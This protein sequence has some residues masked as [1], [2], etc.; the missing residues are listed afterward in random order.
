MSLDVSRWI[1]IYKAIYKKYKPCPWLF[2]C[3]SCC[4][5]PWCQLS[6]IMGFYWLPPTCPARLLC[7]C[8]SDGVPP[9]RHGHRLSVA[10]RETLRWMA[11]CG[12]GSTW[13]NFFLFKVNK[14]YIFCLF[15]FIANLR[16]FK[17]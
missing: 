11:R 2:Y 10:T 9:G 13:G 1:N 7:T 14:L 16:V 17:N 15:V 3:S 4:V 6:T 5:Q 12:G 8:T